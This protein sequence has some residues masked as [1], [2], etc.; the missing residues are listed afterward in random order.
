MRTAI[1]INK[2][3]TGSRQCPRD[4][5]YRTYDA[6]NRML[7]Y[8][9][10][11]LTYDDNGNLTQ[12]Q[13]PVGTVTYNWDSK[14][15]LISINGPNGTA[16]FKY[17]AQGRRIEK[18]INGQTTSFLYDGPQAIAE[19][20]GSAIGATYHTGLQI[21]EVLARY[22]NTGNRTFLTML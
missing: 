12:R 2:E 9:G 13:T 11:P 7:T 6:S 22:T 10:Y 15:Q 18:T 3:Q 5:F 17:D 8:N 21:D 16:S 14:N 4:A 20:Q 1:R 19:L